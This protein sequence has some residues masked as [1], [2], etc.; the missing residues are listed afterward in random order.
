MSL[1]IEK[2]AVLGSGV[3]GAQIAA[4]ITNAGCKVNLLDIPDKNHKNKNNIVDKSI[5]RLI[6]NK[7][8]SFTLFVISPKR[9]GN[10]SP[11]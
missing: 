3:M 2:V 11:S 9:Y 8:N 6:K 4:H 7:P 1:K 5:K 10:L